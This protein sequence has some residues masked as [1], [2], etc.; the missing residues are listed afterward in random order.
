MET[1]QASAIVNCPACFDQVNQAS[2][3]TSCGY[4]IQGT[5]E[6][7]QNFIDQRYAMQIDLDEYEKKIKRAKNYLF[8]LS[9]VCLIWAFIGYHNGVDLATKNALL[10]INV[11]L[12]TLFLVLA[13]WSKAKPT[14]ALISGLVLYVIINV[15]NLVAD[16]TTIIKGI[17]FKILIIAYFIKAINAAI[18]AEKLRKDHNL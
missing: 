18:A 10:A 4:P 11:I 13:V 7:Q 5:A 15:V 8:F 9:A 3:C 16:P 6:E 2:Y 17:I 1:T 14:A 12:S